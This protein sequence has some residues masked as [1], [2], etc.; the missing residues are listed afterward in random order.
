MT[1]DESVDVVLDRSG[2]DEVC[3]V[4]CIGSDDESGQYFIDPSECIDCGACVDTCPVSAI[5]PEDEVP[6]EYRSFITINKVY[7]E[8]TAS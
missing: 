5:Y 1:R 7:F 6:R 4:D 3:P 8:R 2:L